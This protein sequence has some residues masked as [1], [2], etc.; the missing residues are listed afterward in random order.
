MLHLNK[1]YMSYVKDL[2]YIALPTCLYFIF[3]WI[4]TLINIAFLSANYTD[5]RLIEALGLTDLY[6]NCTTY[7]FIVGIASGI[8]ILGANYYGDKNYFYLSITVTKAKL[9]CLVYYI[10][11][12][13]FN[14]VYAMRILIIL[15]NIHDDVISIMRPYFY[16]NL[17]YMLLQISLNADFRYL[18]IIGK[19][20]IN[21][22]VL[23]FTALIHPLINYVLI[24]KMNLSLL[25]CGISIVIIQAI[26]TFGI[27]FYINFYD[28]LPCSNVGFKRQCLEN[29]IEYIKICG[30]T[31]LNTLGE[32]MGF[33]IQALIVMRFSSLDYAVHIIFIN[34][35]LM[36][37]TF[38][39]SVNISLGINI[40]QK[41]LTYSKTKLTQFIKVAYITNKIGLL[42]IVFLLHCMR[43]FVLRSLTTD[44]EMKQIADNTYSILY[45]YAFMNNG[46]YFFSGVL[47]GF[48][49]LIL[50]AIL[51]PF[52]LRL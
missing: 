28:P 11:I 1:E 27:K 33:E 31:T 37:F 35:D 2:L 46:H 20:Y 51:T 32:W 45:V 44:E 29:W 5:Y 26:A 47:R 21:T 48:T 49:Y 41:I 40:A 24:N 9:I 22:I 8:E 36:I 12:T 43:K 3:S 6:L 14:L 39:I 13:I 7:I 23:L 42:S 10:L 16:L 34:I 50:P 4:R 52:L 38:T 15:F 19:S 25:G 30:P 17:A 18:S